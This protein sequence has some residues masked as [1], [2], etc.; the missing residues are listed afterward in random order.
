[1]RLLVLKLSCEKNKIKFNKHHKHSD[2]CK[3]LHF[4]IS[5]TTRKWTQT[6][7]RRPKLTKW[8]QWHNLPPKRRTPIITLNVS[9][10]IYHPQKMMFHFVS[11]CVNKTMKSIWKCF[12]PWK[13]ITFW[14][15][16]DEYFV[17]K[18]ANKKIFLNTK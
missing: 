1:M 8:R 7:M 16:I 10:F 2:L 14:F 9:H 5:K 18:N 15:D 4:T 11:Q 12:G 6:I 13:R 3:S 17:W